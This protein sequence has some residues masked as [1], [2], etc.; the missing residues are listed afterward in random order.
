MDTALMTHHKDSPWGSH[1]MARTGVALWAG[2]L[3]SSRVS[4]RGS[5]INFMAAGW[6]PLSFWLSLCV[7]RRVSTAR[8]WASVAPWLPDEL[9][10]FRSRESPWL[11]DKSPWLHVEPQKLQ[12]EPCIL[13]KELPWPQENLNASRL[14]SLAPCRALR[15]PWWVWLLGEFT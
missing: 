13:Q 9:Y 14:W 4:L 10:G 3:H 5:R 11:L 2:S 8:K 6:A 1:C 15:I 7:T 12:G